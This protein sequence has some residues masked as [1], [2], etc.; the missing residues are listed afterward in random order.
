MGKT[1]AIRI[2]TEKEIV[3]TG[4]DHLLSVSSSCTYSSGNQS[5]GRW[6]KCQQSSSKWSGGFSL[7]H[8]MSLVSC[9]VG[10]FHGCTLLNRTAEKCTD[11][12]NWLIQIVP[13]FKIVRDSKPL[14]THREHYVHYSWPHLPALIRRSIPWNKRWNFRRLAWKECLFKIWSVQLPHRSS[15]NFDTGPAWI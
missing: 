6:R 12:P 1:S 14:A 4:T 9:H 3:R 5:T 13:D 7:G 11:I 8:R 10:I 2:S 15:E